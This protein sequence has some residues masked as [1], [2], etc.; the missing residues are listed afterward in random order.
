MQAAVSLP[1]L[2]P[3]YED[4][5]VG[6]MLSSGP[7]CYDPVATSTSQL[8][9]CPLPHSPKK[10]TVRINELFATLDQTLL[11]ACE[12]PGDISFKSLESS[13]IDVQLSEHDQLPLHKPRLTGSWAS[14]SVG[15]RCLPEQ[16]QLQVT[17]M[18]AGKC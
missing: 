12:L 14:A 2:N 1:A 9:P 15:Q 4:D 11:S 17:N 5:D 10:A 18:A 6:S 7:S 8:A 3:L 16:S 13:N